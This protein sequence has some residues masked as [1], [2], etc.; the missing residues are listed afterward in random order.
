MF[1]VVCWTKC[2]VSL[3]Q[4]KENRAIRKRKYIECVLKNTG[5]TFVQFRFKKSYKCDSELSQPWNCRQRMQSG[6]F[7]V[8]SFFR[9]SVREYL[10]SVVE[11]FYTSRVS[12]SDDNYKNYLYNL[13]I[14]FR[15]R[16]GMCSWCFFVRCWKLYLSLVN[17]NILDIMYEMFCYNERWITGSFAASLRFL[18][19]L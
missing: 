10:C 7:V 13:R 19:D 15:K 1:V 2:L 5:K 9:R 17:Q 18:R 11:V 14:I 8:I 6:N 4:W 3:S 12:V 16:V